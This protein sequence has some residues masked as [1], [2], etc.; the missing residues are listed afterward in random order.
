MTHRIEISDAINAKRAAGYDAEFEALMRQPWYCPHCK[1][2]KTILNVMIPMPGSG[3]EATEACSDCGKEGV[4][5]VQG[6]QQYGLRQMRRILDAIEPFA[7]AGT[8]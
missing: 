5:H 4:V 8:A 7:K 2:S 3:P 6:G 1:A